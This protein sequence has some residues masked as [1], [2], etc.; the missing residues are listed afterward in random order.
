MASSGESDCV[1][2]TLVGKSNPESK[3]T[4]VAQ[5]ILVLR[6]RLPPHHIPVLI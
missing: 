5:A 4:E 3:P 6:S 2:S 1:A